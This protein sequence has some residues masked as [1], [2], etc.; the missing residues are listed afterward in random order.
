MN[1]E[2]LAKIRWHCRR[3]MLELDVILQNFF[4]QHYLQ[5]SSKEQQIFERLLETEDQQLYDWFL[6]K[7]QSRNIELAAM[8][9][10]IIN[11]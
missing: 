8:V 2:K 9:K 3:G 6:Q 1:K 11:F 10:K 7:S 5:L 4:D